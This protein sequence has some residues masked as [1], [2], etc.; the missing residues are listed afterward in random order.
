M[1]NKLYDSSYLEE[2]QSFFRRTKERSYELLL[3]CD[4]DCIVDVGCGTGADVCRIA[5]SGAT[6]VG[7]DH[8]STYIQ[9]ATN[10]S[11]PKN[12]SF[13]CCEAAQIP[14]EASSIN[15]IRFDRVFQ[16]IQ[17]HDESLTAA[18]H[19]LKDG[20]QLQ[21]IDSDYLSWAIFLEDWELERKILYSLAYRRIPHAHKVRELPRR[22]SEHGF[23]VDLIEVHNY[24]VK[25]FELANYII[26][27]DSIVEDERRSNAISASE[28]IAWENYKNRPSSLFNLSINQILIV[29]SKK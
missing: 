17:N 16:H 3:P 7:V 6:V 15:K 24:M 14:F 29:A 11:H 23:E 26:K 1:A 12:A 21:I 18:H 13:I 28:L 19:A 4:N 20:G 22:L 27:F 25:D 9:I 2:M 10:Q 5:Q 8:D